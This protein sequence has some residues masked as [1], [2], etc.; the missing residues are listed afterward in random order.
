M[1][2]D[3]APGGRRRSSL[4]ELD[5]AEL[6]RPL[7]RA[8]ARSRYAGRIAR[9]IVASARTPR[10]RR[11]RSSP[12]SSTRAVPDAPRAAAASI[13]PPA[14]SRRSASPSTRELDALRGRSAAAWPAPA[15][16]PAR[17]PQLPLARGP[18]RQALHRGR[19]AGLHL[20]ARAARLRLRPTS[21]ACGPSARSPSGPPRGGRRQP[22]VPERP[23]AGRRAAR[24]M[25]PTARG[26]A[27]LPSPSQPNRRVG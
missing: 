7:P 4:A 9:A 22:P 15:G 13:P 3:P 1:R 19:A 18:H 14:S 26:G 8:T 20:P 25:S 21:P 12:R 16:R 2:F 6:T 5:G 10:S 27:P 24:R 17:R 11:P 23:A